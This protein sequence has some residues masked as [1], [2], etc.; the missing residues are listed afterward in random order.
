MVGFVENAKGI[1]SIVRDG[2]ITLILILLLFVPAMVN[3]SLIAAG[4]TEGDVGGFKWKA[5]VQENTAKLSGAAQTID[6]LQDQLDK[7]Q[8][9]LKDS[10]DSRI[11]LTDQVAET[12]PGAATAATATA[13]PPHATEV[14]LQQN[15]RVLKSAESRGSV[16]RAQIQ[17]NEN[18]LSTVPRQ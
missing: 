3:K 7:T 6:T 12:D 10:E 8:T 17:A 11:K 13:P 2:L 15:S 4:F 18:L 1:V 5:A 14:I 9:A 16:L